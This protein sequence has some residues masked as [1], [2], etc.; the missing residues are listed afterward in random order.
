MKTNKL[1]AAALLPLL[2][3]CAKE[4][5]AP[6]ETPENAD[7]YIT[8]NLVPG[9][10]T[11]TKASFHD[12]EGIIW[13]SGG[14]AGIVNA[15][16][17]NIKS[18][19]LDN[20]YD[21][22]GNNQASFKFLKT[23]LEGK[24]GPYV[25]YYPH[26]D[27]VSVSDDGKYT[28]PVFVDVTQ[29]SDIGKSTEI[30][31]VVS[32]KAFDLVP[33][34]EPDKD[35]D[36]DNNG[37]DVEFKVVGSYIRILPYGGTKEGE[38]LDYIKIYDINEVN[39]VSGRYFVSVAVNNDNTTTISKTDASDLLSNEM[40]VNFE[41][42]PKTKIDKK[43]AAGIYAQVLSGKHQLAYELHTKVG[44]TTN[45]YIFKSSRETDFAFGSIKDIPLNIE[46][47]T[48]TVSSPEK[49]YI[50]G[51]VSFVGWNHSNAIEMSKN[52]YI[53]TTN[54]YLNTQVKKDGVYQAAEGF[55]FILQND[56]FEPAYVNGGDNT[57]KKYNGG[58]GDNKFTVDKAGYYTV[59]ADFSTGKVTCTSAAPD[60]FYIWGDATEA[61]WNSDKAIPLVQDKNDKFVFTKEGIILN[62]GDYKFFSENSETTAYVNDDKGNLVFFDS[63]SDTDKDI[64]FKVAYD[65]T[66]DLTV[67]LKDNSVKCIL[68]TIP[69]ARVKT[70]DWTDMEK[71]EEPGVFKAAAW[72]IKRGDDNHDIQIRCGENQYINSGYYKEVTFASRTESLTGMTFDVS[73]KDIVDEKDVNAKYSWWINDNWCKVRYDIIFDSNKNSVTIKYV[74]A[75]YFWLVGHINNW[76]IKDDN[77]KADVVDGVATWNIDVAG[78]YTDIKICGEELYGV[79]DE[80]FDVGCE[81]YYSNAADGNVDVSAGREFDVM[82]YNHDHKWYFPSGKYKVQF[83][84]NTFKLIVE[85]SN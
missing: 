67:N 23:E 47:A 62:K 12:V 52:G 84:A 82:T 36:Y 64:K 74:P 25:L 8:V 40:Y 44:N 9:A 11:V 77:Y 5:I 2:F 54:V 60:K 65:G 15:A 61:A 31:S 71:T 4:N 18:K 66:Y 35:T 75:K 69:Q 43:D 24:P 80:L 49:L 72:W 41:S 34:K 30:F 57:L 7:D 17:N 16:G 22:K 53:F 78:S 6:A 38:I 26:H 21:W 45:T 70:G 76:T 56:S 59:T 14:Y 13:Q 68:K 10:D 63:P 55:K 37:A 85:K 1:I 33:Y 50:V 48:K 79:G 29:Q 27:E 28:I 83:N 81:W 32:K 51:D 3:S 19:G 58:D 20:I 73:A 42:K 46:K 39:K